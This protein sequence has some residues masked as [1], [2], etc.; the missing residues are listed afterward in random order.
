[1]NRKDPKRAK[2]DAE[3]ARNRKKQGAGN[4]PTVTRDPTDPEKEELK[5]ALH[6]HEEKKGDWSKGH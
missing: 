1:M 6:E 3:T 4:V 2:R 5:K